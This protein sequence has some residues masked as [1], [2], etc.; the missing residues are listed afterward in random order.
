[1]S[2]HEVQR[3]EAVP[4][5]IYS[6]KESVLLKK[7]KQMPAEL[8]PKVEKILNDHEVLAPGVTRD[9]DGR[10]TIDCGTTVGAVVRPPRIKYVTQKAKRKRHG[11]FMPKKDRNR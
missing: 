6:E 11:A 8:V 1:M 7:L 2:N 10:I 9:A 3:P 5:R 4:I